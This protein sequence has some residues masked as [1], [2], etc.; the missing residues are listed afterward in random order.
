MLYLVAQGSE[1]QQRWRRPL[2]TG[3]STTLG[4]TGAGWNAEWDEQISRVHAELTMDGRRLRV[5]RCG[6]STNPVFFR[7]KELDEFLVSP[8]E[9][10]VIGGTRF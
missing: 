1:S 4:R 7:G 10:F 3:Q 6:E 8:G 2:L 5:K 9:H